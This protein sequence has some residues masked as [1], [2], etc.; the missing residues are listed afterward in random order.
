[1][2][3]PSRVITPGKRGQLPER[4]E[5]GY[6]RGTVSYQRYEG[7]HLSPVMVK[8]SQ[9]EVSE[10]RPD[11]ITAGADEDVTHRG[12]V[13][14]AGRQARRNLTQLCFQKMHLR[15]DSPPLQAMFMV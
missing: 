11:T 12:S 8:A 7:D 4:D 3:R 15:S 14:Q 6:R 9:V 2:P 5:H 10:S 13:I 1:M